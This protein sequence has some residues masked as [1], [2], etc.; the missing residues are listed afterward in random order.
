MLPFI[1]PEM[2]EW[3]LR[4]GAQPEDLSPGEDPIAGLNQD[5][6]NDKTTASQ[7]QRQ[8]GHGKR[9]KWEEY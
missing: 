7:Q 3:L 4:W 2:F 8:K 1:G 6:G 9:L 5:A